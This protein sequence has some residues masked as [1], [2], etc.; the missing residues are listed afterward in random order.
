MSGIRSNGLTRYATMAAV[1]SITTAGTFFIAA[2]VII[3]QH[4]YEVLNVTYGISDKRYIRKR[5]EL[6]IRIIE[7]IKQHSRVFCDGFRSGFY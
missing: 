5:P 7:K 4:G 2:V 1:P 3:M 6:C